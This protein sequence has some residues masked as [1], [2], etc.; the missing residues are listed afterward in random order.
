[1]IYTITPLLAAKVRSQNI[2]HVFGAFSPRTIRNWEM[3]KKISGTQS[4][5]HV[6]IPEIRSPLNRLLL[7]LNLKYILT[8]YI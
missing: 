6:T 5:L 3:E 1:M 2:W 8:R 7:S 4:A